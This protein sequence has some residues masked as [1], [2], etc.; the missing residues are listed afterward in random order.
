[1]PVFGGDLR[2][3]HGGDA[4]DI[5][6]LLLDLLGPGSG[7]VD[8]VDDRQDLQ[9]VVDGQ[10]RVGQRLGL[11]ALGGVHDKDRAL[12]GC[13][14]PGDFVVEVHVAWRVDQV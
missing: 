2:R 12:A 11:D 6:H 5:L 4:D 9:V 13:Q 8:L 1:M 7:Q 14:A 3:V 10:I